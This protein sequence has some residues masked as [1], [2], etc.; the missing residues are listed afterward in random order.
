[1]TISGEVSS[2]NESY[3]ENKYFKPYVNGIAQAAVAYFNKEDRAIYSWAVQPCA[4]NWSRAKGCPEP[5]EVWQIIL[6]EYINKK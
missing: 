3:H 2:K 4:I 6:D 1:V 5:Q